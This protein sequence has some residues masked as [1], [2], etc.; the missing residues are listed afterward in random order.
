LTK[1]TTKR[2]RFTSEQLMALV[3]ALGSRVITEQDF[4]QAGEYHLFTDPTVKRAASR[5]TPEER[6]NPA[7]HLY[8]A[9]VLWSDR[10]HQRVPNWYDSVINY[11]E[12]AVAFDPGY[13]ARAR[14]YLKQ[15]YRA[16]EKR[17]GRK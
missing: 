12:D 10:S 9:G 5:G 11:M 15:A 4:A 1:Q 8:Q 13:E 14:K 7:W 6:D 16:K 2:D 3:A 17:E